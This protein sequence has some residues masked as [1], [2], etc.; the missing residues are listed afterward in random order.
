MN[1]IAVSLACIVLACGCA[2]TVSLNQEIMQAYRLQGE[3]NYETALVKWQSIMKTNPTEEVRAEAQYN[4]GR[5]Y[6]GMDRKEEALAIFTALADLHPWERW[7]AYS[8][9]AVAEHNERSGNFEQALEGYEGI[10]TKYGRYVKIKK[11][12]FERDLK[13]LNGQRR[14]GRFPLD[15]GLSDALEYLYIKE[16]LISAYHG[17]AGYYERRKKDC[18]KAISVYKIVTEEFPDPEDSFFAMLGILGCRIDFSK[19]D[20]FTRASEFALAN[21]E[22]RYTPGILHLVGIDLLEKGQVEKAIETFREVISR[23][24]DTPAAVESYLSLGEHYTKSGRDDEALKVFE[25]AL[26][27]YPFAPNAAI[28]R[29]Y[30]EKIKQAPSK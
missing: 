24:P 2:G 7:G 11:D 15:E 27:E 20:S 28:I 8:L 13:R 3:E 25:K 1:R 19:D 21:P 10:G 22:N 29:A 14:M 6:Y 5:C 18:G 23:Y 9:W 16:V 17:S 12:T 4:I 30:I 26:M